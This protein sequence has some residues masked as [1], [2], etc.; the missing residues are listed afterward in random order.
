M[1]PE[2]VQSAITALRAYGEAA[3]WNFF[4]LDGRLIQHDLS[5]IAYALKSDTPITEEELISG[6]GITQTERG[7]EWE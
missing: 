1:R 5:D 2:N 7:Y 6:L 3:R 4:A